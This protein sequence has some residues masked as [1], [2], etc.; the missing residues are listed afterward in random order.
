MKHEITP[1]TSVQILGNINDLS[2]Q[3]QK[4]YFQEG[5]VIQKAKTKESYLVLFEDGHKKWFSSKNLYASPFKFEKLIDLKDDVKLTLDLC[6][7]CKGDHHIIITAWHPN[8]IMYRR[9]DEEKGK[10]ERTSDEWKNLFRNIKETIFDK[11]E[12]YNE[13]ELTGYGFEKY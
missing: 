12:S 2:I 11:I 13:K 3:N 8:A 7:T 4:Y 1:G 5:K 10:D 6:R 9:W